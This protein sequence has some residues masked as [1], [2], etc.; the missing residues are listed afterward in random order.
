MAFL[1]GIPQ[2]VLTVVC[3][4]HGHLYYIGRYI[5]NLE[6]AS[7]LWAGVTPWTISKPQGCQLWGWDWRKRDYK[8][9]YWRTGTGYEATRL[10]EQAH[11]CEVLNVSFEM[12]TEVVDPAGI[13]GKKMLLPGEVSTATGWLGGEV[14]RSHSSQPSDK[15]VKDWTI[16]VFNEPWSYFMLRIVFH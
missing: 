2:F 4:Q 15:L 3:A 13:R 5:I 11:H 16:M 12:N 6:G 1:R 9:W 8:S 10:D 7:P 14:S